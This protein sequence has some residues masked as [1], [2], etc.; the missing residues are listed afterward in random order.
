MAAC[1]GCSRRLLHRAL[2]LVVLAYPVAAG[3]VLT[4][5][6][7]HR[8]TNAIL[9]RANHRQGQVVLD[10]A[11]LTGV[12]HLLPGVAGDNDGA[13]RN[14]HVQAVLRGLSRNGRY[15]SAIISAEQGAKMCA[16]DT[17]GRRAGLQPEAIAIAFAE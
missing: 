15:A 3:I 5:C 7:R 1:P 14:V 4:D 2:C 8:H 9:R 10:E 13:T 11:E 17:D 6:L 12:D 16:A